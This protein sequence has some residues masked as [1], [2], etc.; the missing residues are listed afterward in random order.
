MGIFDEQNLLLEPGLDD[1]L[2]ADGSDVLV[3]LG[4]QATRDRRQFPDDGNRFWP[5]PI[6]LVRNFPDI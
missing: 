1:L 6:D 4:A 2:L 5:I 3:I